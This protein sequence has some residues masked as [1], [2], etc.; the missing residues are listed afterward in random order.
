MSTVPSN[1]VPTRITQLPEYQ[2]VDPNGYVAYVYG[3]VTYKVQL[4]QVIAAVNVPPT[5]AINTGT[6]LTGGG[7]LT[8]D[9]TISIQNQGVGYNQL[10]KSG[11]VAGTYGTATTVPQIVVDDTGRVT[12]VTELP[13]IGRAHV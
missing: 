3:G 13:K 4:S 6:G 2:G 7:N 9:R 10:A 8:Q 12:S 1:L 5:R 11:A